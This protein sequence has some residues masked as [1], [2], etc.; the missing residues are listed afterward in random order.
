MR[1]INNKNKAFFS[2]EKYKGI[3]KTYLKHCDAILFIFSLVNKNSFYN[4][5]NW[6]QYYKESNSNRR[7][8]HKY[9]IGN[10]CD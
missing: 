6:I 4:I 9:L 8:V 10:K 3:T 2:Q 1:F 7:E 5:V